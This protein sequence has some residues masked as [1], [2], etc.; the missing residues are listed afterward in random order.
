VFCLDDNELSHLNQRLDKVGIKNREAFIRKMVLDGS[1][2]DIDMK[3]TMELNRIIRNVASNIN[4]IAKRCNETGS[5]YEKDARELREEV[6]QLVPL[7]LNAQAELIKL[8]K[9]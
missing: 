2:I 3:P 7:V 5:A 8:C 9:M 6:C 1:I 4:Q